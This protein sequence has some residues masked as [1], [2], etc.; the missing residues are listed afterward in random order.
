MRAATQEGFTERERSLWERFKESRESQG[1]RVFTS[2][3]CPPLIE[4]VIW[5]E[6]LKYRWSASATVPF[7]GLN[8]IVYAQKTSMFGRDLGAIPKCLRPR[9]SAHPSAR[10]P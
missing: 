6:F 7:G 1:A 8:P 10:Q 5:D 3:G 4:P 9:G 2:L